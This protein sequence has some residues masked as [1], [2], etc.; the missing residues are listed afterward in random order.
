MVSKSLRVFLQVE[1]STV[2][3]RGSMPRTSRRWRVVEVQARFDGANVM[4]SN[5][6]ASLRLDLGGNDGSPFW[7]GFKSCPSAARSLFSPTSN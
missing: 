4:D 7:K 1:D 6:P 2:V 3:G 5:K